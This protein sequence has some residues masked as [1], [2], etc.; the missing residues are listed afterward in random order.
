MLLGASGLAIPADLGNAGLCAAIKEAH[1]CVIKG[2]LVIDEAVF[3]T[4]NVTVIPLNNGICLPSA[5]SA[6]ML[7]ALLAPGSTSTLPLMLIGGVTCSDEG[8]Y[9]W[10]NVWKSSGAVAVVALLG[11]LLAIVVVASVVDAVRSA[12]R[13][14]PSPGASLGYDVPRPAGT[15]VFTEDGLLFP[16]NAT[17]KGDEHA[18]LLGQLPRSGM[19]SVSGASALAAGAPLPGKD[20][21]ALRILLAFS[22]IHN[23]K[24]LVVQPPA[25]LNSLNGM[26]FFSMCFIIIGH[27]VLNILSNPGVDDLSAVFGPKILATLGL[28]DADLSP[29]TG[30]VYQFPFQV[31]L[32]AEFCTLSNGKSI[33]WVLFVAHR[34]VRL[35]PALGLLVL[36]YTVLVPYLGDGPAW[37]AVVSN[38]RTTCVEH[39]RWLATLGFVNNFTPASF[40]NICA[41]WTWYLSND[42]QFF[43]VLAPLSI[44]AFRAS[45]KTGLFVVSFLSALGIA[46]GLG[47]GAA[48]NLSANLLSGPGE[49]NQTNEFYGK[50][51]M[52]MPAYLIG[53]GLAGVLDWLG[54]TRGYA[55]RLPPLVRWLVYAAAF[56]VM[57]LTFFGQYSNI[58][59]G[60]LAGSWPK[61]TRVA[62][63][64]L[65]R[66]AWTLGLAAVVYIYISGDGG[67]VAAFLSAPV[68]AGLARLTYSAYLWHYV[69]MTVVFGNATALSRYRPDFIAVY[70]SFF[71]ISAYIMSLISYLLVEKPIMNL[72]KLLLG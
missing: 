7:E 52:R 13:S 37:P 65:S 31:V 34:F 32:G 64:A 71:L 33:N 61:A 27:T 59:G 8:E 53:V 60:D 25:L 66:P 68:F 55:P 22:A 70:T 69:I 10:A 39:H 5:C 12:I 28:T 29:R 46:L 21:L 1:M 18:L 58:K 47:I 44:L 2:E 56:T 14:P 45:F 38:V 72:E 40:G 3:P 49:G 11:T 24:R 19:P 26:R 9:R 17:G 62:Y 41:G 36:V 30:A 43:L 6:S 50:P 35:L 16:V 23:L 67:P 42:M 48:N 51:Y 57:G 63:L 4:S 20:P 54:R 15:M